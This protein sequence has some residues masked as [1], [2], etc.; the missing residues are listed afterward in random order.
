[1]IAFSES[2]CLAILLSLKVAGVATLLSLP[3]GFAVA[4]A[5]T[6]G[7]FRERSSST[8]WSIFPDPAARRHRLSASASAGPERMARPG[9]P[10]APRDQADLHVEGRRHRHGRCRLSPHGAIDPHG[11]GGHRR[12]SGSGVPNPGSRMA[13]HNRHGDPAPVVSRRHRRIGPHVCPWSGRIRGH[14]HRGGATSPA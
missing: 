11:D 6:Y 12:A 13:G 10:P 8:Y 14:H 2:D 7:R 9:G 4:Y 5:M 3:F 1:M